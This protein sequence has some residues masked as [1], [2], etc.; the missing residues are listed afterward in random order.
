MCEQDESESS[1]FEEDSTC[2]EEV[3]ATLNMIDLLKKNIL[4]LTKAKIGEIL[5]LETTIRNSLHWIFNM[6][7]E[8]NLKSN[9]LMV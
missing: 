7:K 1:S 8:V 4:P 2:H 6:R 3:V 5:G 9:I